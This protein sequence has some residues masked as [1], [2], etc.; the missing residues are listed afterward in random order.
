MKQLVLLTVFLLGGL[1]AA[2]SQDYINSTQANAEA[3]LKKKYPA[4]SGNSQVIVSRDS[5]RVQWKESAGGNTEYICAFDDKGL[6]LSETII[7]RCDSCLS[8]YLQQ[9]LNKKKFEWKKIN[10]NQYVSR[11]ADNLMIELSA[12]AAHPSFSVLRVD[13]TRQLYDLLMKE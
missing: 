8:G 7:T 9:V 12:D 11:F 5:I 6:C 3:A 2:R 10:E 1:S 4:K 13:W